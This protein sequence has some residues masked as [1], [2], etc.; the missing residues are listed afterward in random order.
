V[1]LFPDRAYLVSFVI[2]YKARWRKRSAR[3]MV[4]YKSCEKE[5]IKF[6]GKELRKLLCQI[7]T[8]YAF[9]AHID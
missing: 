7:N 8:K 4:E 3:Y 9:A 5:Q 2:I 6:Q 1:I